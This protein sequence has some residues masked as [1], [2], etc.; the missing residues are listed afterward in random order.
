MLRMWTWAC[1]RQAVDWTPAS[2]TCSRNCSGWLA[3]ARLLTAA[4]IRS[5]LFQHLMV[6]DDECRGSV[7]AKNAREPQGP[8]RRRAMGPVARVSSWTQGFRPSWTKPK[9]Y[10]PIRSAATSTTRSPAGRGNPRRPLPGD[11]SV[12]TALTV[13]GRG[14]RSAGPAGP[15]VRCA[16]VLAVSR[17]DGQRRRGCA[18]AM[19]A[20]G[21]KLFQMDATGTHAVIERIGPRACWL[22][23][24]QTRERLRQAK[25]S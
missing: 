2:W 7:R 18:D 20:A 23:I 25:A 17:R 15:H 10:S 3:A 24:E 8:G 6:R 21:K 22:S 16:G 13:R 1:G 12:G 5:G 11:Q 9:L 14:R 4:W 19:R